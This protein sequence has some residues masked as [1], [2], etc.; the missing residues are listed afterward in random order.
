MTEHSYKTTNSE[1]E[2]CYPYSYRKSISHQCAII[3]LTCIK[4]LI[5]W[6]TGRVG[7]LLPQYCT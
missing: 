4:I 1:I 5:H 7:Q 6:R 3:E 2:N